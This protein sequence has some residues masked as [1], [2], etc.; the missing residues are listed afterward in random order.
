MEL[1]A[2]IKHLF[3]SLT[4]SVESFMELK[5]IAMSPDPP[6]FKFLVESFMEL[7]GEGGYL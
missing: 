4:K 1:K 7:K 5:A 6:N 2:D 3:L